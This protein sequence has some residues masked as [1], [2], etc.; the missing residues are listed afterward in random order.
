MFSKILKKFKQSHFFKFLLIIFFS[1]FGSIFAFLYLFV[2][3]KLLSPYDFG[4]LNSTNSLL[5]LFTV[6]VS[7]LQVS[8]VR[9][10][11]FFKNKLKNKN[12]LIIFFKSFL[13]E[14]FCLCLLIIL[15]LIVINKF[16][17]SL[18][19]FSERYL[20][21]IIYIN[22]SLIFL[23]SPFNIYLLVN[24]KYFFQS[25]L[26]SMQS[27]FR[28]FFFILFFILIT[29]S[30]Y[31]GLLANIGSLLLVI[32]FF[33]FYF[34][35]NYNLNFNSKNFFKEIIIFKNLNISSLL[36]CYILLTGNFDSVIFI[37]L[38]PNETAGY[39]SGI[40]SIAKIPLFFCSL[41][42]NYIYT[43]TID[44]KFKKKNN[45]KLIN[46]AS[47]FFLLSIL[48]IQIIYY[49]FGE[50]ILK[51]VFNTNFSIFHKEFFILSAGYS[52]LVIIHFIS[53]FLVAIKPF[54]FFLFLFLSFIL[55]LIFLYNFSENI[56]DFSIN[57][58]YIFILQFTVLILYLFF[59]KICKTFKTKNSL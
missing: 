45:K 5:A 42:F 13:F 39:Y 7:I 1:T 57:I 40:S 23:I 28:L 15:I 46:S 56:K 6:P 2:G 37:K 4:I 32:I 47:L 3:G 55:S 8:A 41:A 22:I 54:K 38:F 51:M 14:V 12:N 21:Y 10:F 36:I 9:T 33:L 24:K 25:I 19:Q 11:A 53:Y 16:F 29:K 49:F 35:I 26:S 27:F 50:L 18:P 31:S 58:L 48:S 30:Y 52:I 20:T 43:E 59:L 34:K 17:L 44:S